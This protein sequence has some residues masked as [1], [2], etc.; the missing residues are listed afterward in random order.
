MTYYLNNYYKQDLNKH[1]FY[2]NYERIVC[3]NDPVFFVSAA[4]LC[5]MYEYGLM[6]VNVG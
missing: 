3:Q 2:T 1:T 6:G 4:S 5:E